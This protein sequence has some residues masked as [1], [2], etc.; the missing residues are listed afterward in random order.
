MA[1]SEAGGAGA[2]AAVPRSVGPVLLVTGVSGFVVGAFA[3]PSWQVAVETAQVLAGLVTYPADNPFYSYHTRLWTILHQV[4]AVPLWLGM[5]ERTLSILLSGVLGMLAFQASGLIV[6]V[7]GSD[8]LIAVLAAFFVHD[9]H[10]DFGIVYPLIVTGHSHTYG[11]LALPYTLLG[12]ALVS[13]AWYRTGGFLLGMAP[14]V[15]PTVGSWALAV[16]LACLALDRSWRRPHGGPL[17]GGLGSGL[18]VSIASLLIHLATS[19]TAPLASPDEAR[20]CF[21]A[22]VASWDSHRRAF[23]LRSDGVALAAAT[24]LLCLYW[25]RMTRHESASPC[26]FLLRYG[27]LSGLGAAALSVTHWMPGSQAAEAVLALMPGRLLNSNIFMLMP[28]VIGLLVRCGPAGPWVLVAFLTG[29]RWLDRSVQPAARLAGAAA[30]ALLPVR[31]GNGLAGSPGTAGLLGRAAALAVM[32]WPAYWI[33]R[34]VPYHWRTSRANIVDH[35]EDAVLAAARRG[36]GLLATGAA[37]SRVQLRTRRPVLIDGGGLDALSLFPDTGP[38]TNRILKA[39]YGVDLFAPPPEA[40]RTA[41]IPARVSRRT[42]EARSRD[43]WGEIGRRFAV[44]QVMTR[45]DWK[46][47]LPEVARNERLALYDI[48]R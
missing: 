8:P 21:Q 5:E 28:L 40:L 25:L 7:A 41:V 36:R 10:F 22:F 4:C 48:P 30:C 35:R 24:V 12:V 47:D 11:M 23:S 3:R 13:A 32:L 31:S 18:A 27:A 14:A 39:V 9:R 6:L 46:L 16:S 44:T 37:L 17:I 1:A 2:R 34:S 43:A 26:R 29:S 45:A 33:V 38:G 15:H 42:W 19:H 20:T